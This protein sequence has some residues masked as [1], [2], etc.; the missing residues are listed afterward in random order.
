MPY[1]RYGRINMMKIFFNLLILICC[2]ILVLCAENPTRLKIRFAKTDEAEIDLTKAEYE[3]SM[4]VISTIYDV[5]EKL[6]V[7][8]NRNVYTGFVDSIY[9]SR[10]NTAALKSTDIAAL[11]FGFVWSG[12]SKY[13]KEG[14]YLVLTGRIYG[15]DEKNRSRK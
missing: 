2:S 15:L 12:E 9:L 5:Y 1:I 11:I 6:E 7:I 10:I 8:D 4:F 14:Y 3:A 13:I